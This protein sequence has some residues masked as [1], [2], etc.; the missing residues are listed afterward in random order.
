MLADRHGLDMQNEMVRQTF[1]DRG[2]HLAVNLKDGTV[3]VEILV[4]TC[5]NPM[6]HDLDRAERR[7]RIASL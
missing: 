1:L 3:R 7:P 6:V 5:L 4:C 2:D